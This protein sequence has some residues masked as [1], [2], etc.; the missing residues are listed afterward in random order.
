MVLCYCLAYILWFVFSALSRM[1]IASL[2]FQELFLKGSANWF[3]P[4]LHQDFADSTVRKEVVG[5]ELEVFFIQF[6]MCV[7][8][9]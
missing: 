5:F 2:V 1:M 8:L 6:L 9:T 4:C 3:V 7:S